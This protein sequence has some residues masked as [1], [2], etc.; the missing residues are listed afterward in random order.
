MKKIT[1]IALAAIMTSAVAA[2]AAFAKGG[3]DGWVQL[4]KMEQKRA[5]LRA[6]RTKGDKPSVSELVQKIKGAFSS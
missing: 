1:V 3:G 2:P 4:E 6:D 5:E